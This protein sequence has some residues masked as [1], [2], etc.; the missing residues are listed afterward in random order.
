MKILTGPKGSIEH[1]TFTPDGRYITASRDNGDTQGIE[2]WDVA[3]GKQVRTVAPDRWIR[4]YVLHPNGKWAFGDTIRMGDDIAMID[5]ATGAETG[6]KF[7]AYKG[8][9]VAI[10]A[11]GARL[12]ASVHA[13]EGSRAKGTRDW[14]MCW[15]F[16]GD[17]PKIAWKRERT[18]REPIPYC[19]AFLPDD[20]LVTFEGRFWGPEKSQISQLAIRDATSGEYIETT[21]CEGAH[22]VVVSPDG[23]KIVTR[24]GKKI[25]IWNAAQLSDEPLTITVGMNPGWYAASF[26]GYSFAF[27]PSGQ[28]L[29]ATRNDKTVRIYDSVTW[30]P[31]KTLTWAAGNLQ[32]VCFSPDGAL[33]AVSGH[34]GKVVVWDVD[35]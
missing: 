28:F 16:V 22:A 6:L 34:T 4:W 11:D 2:F 35:L 29:A 8:V 9:G 15:K 27:H 19:V 33:G 24:W 20:R 17:Q 5:L 1:L 32:G 7:V 14:L 21:K 31:L 26:T 18:I 13:Q 23:T 30:K 10:S 12:V 3:A 25:Q